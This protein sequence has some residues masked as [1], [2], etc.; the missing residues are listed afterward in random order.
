M[1]STSAEIYVFS[2]TGNTF[3]LVDTIRDILTSNNCLTTIHPIP[4]K[5]YPAPPDCALG[6]AF[7]T[8][9]C[10]TYPFV[11]DFIKA[12]PDGKGREAFII[13]SMASTHLNMSQPIRRLLV[14]KG[15][16]PIGSRILKMPSNYGKSAS[17]KSIGNQ[18]IIKAA[19]VQAANYAGQ[20]LTGKSS[21]P[22]KT[23]PW[24]NW[25][26]KF[27]QTKLPWKLFRKLFK[28]KINISR[29]TKCGFCQTICPADAITLQNGC[30][31]TITDNCVSCQHCMAYCPQKA[32][33]INGDCGN[34]YK[35]FEY[36]E[37][38]DLFA[39]KQ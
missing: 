4:G 2:G 23:A 30:Y 11:L 9:W 24:S 31:Y 5:F 29:C 12:L 39:K 14:K 13:S 27:A 25:L 28:L 38:I 17:E 35:T 26:Y 37:M 34:I 19:V 3:L 6:L 21:W 8:A 32:I 15:Y 16:R 10:S 20:L 18:E 1:K 7:T 33:G 22:K 36:Q